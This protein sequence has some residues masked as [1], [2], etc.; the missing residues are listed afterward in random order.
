VHQ[1]V[2]HLRC[3][4]D[5]RVV[6]R[7]V[8]QLTRQPRS[9]LPPL[10]DNH[11]V[12]PQVDPRVNQLIGPANSQLRSLLRIQLASPLASPVYNRQ[13]GRRAVLLLFPVRNQLR[14]PAA[15]LRASLP[16]SLHSI[17]H[18]S[19]PVLRHGSPL[20]GQACNRP[21]SQQQDQRRSRRRFHRC[22][23][24]VA[25]LRSRQVYRPV[26][27]LRVLPLNHPV[28]QQFNLPPRLPRSHPDNLQIIQLTNPLANRRRSR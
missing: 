18:R 11:Q 4:R 1:L 8:S 14:C 22:S 16:R 20:L 10:P 21:S 24:A 25:H 7:V 12:S 17:R 6:C 19:L 28:A 27:Q 23:R 9:R 13:A 2:S 15:N 5:S 26:S 3:L